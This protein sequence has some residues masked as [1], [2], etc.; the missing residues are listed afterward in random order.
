A[1]SATVTP[2][3]APIQP[4]VEQSKPQLAAEQPSPQPAAEQPEP[5]AAKAAAS[6]LAEAAAQADASPLAEAAADADEDN[7]DEDELGDP[8]IRSRYNADELHNLFRNRYVRAEEQPEQPAPAPKNLEN[9]QP[10]KKF[11]GTNKHSS[12][13]PMPAVARAY[14][15]EI[16]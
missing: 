3:A 11:V 15:P 6:A 7:D 13:D 8:R 5:V 2:E 1:A 9:S 14:P 16:R 12:T 4:T 10:T